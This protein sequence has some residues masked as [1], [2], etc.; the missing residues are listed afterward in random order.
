MANLLGGDGW[1]IIREIVRERKLNE[2]VE[3]MK[4]NKKKSWKRVRVNTERAVSAVRF[5]AAAASSSS[6]EYGVCLS[7]LLSLSNSVAV[8]SN[9]YYGVNGGDTIRDWGGA[10]NA[11]KENR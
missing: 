10:V 8:S 2:R 4:A 3:K 1:N 6:F 7:L 11:M 5:K 9:Y